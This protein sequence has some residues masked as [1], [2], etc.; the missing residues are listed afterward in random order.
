MTNLD[1]AAA[2]VLLRAANLIVTEGHTKGDFVTSD[3]YCAAGAIGTACGLRPYDWYDDNENAP[4]R[5][6]YTTDGHLDDE[7]Y[8]A[9]RQAWKTGRAAALAALRTLAAHIDADSTPELLA[10]MSRRQLLETVGDWNDNDE[11]VEA[12]QVVT[13]MRTA[14][15]E[16]VPGRV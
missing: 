16:A 10:T 12:E 4:N 15:R 7:A 5:R 14:A 8:E 13:A 3:G 11:D 2:P 9:D 1:L 6:D